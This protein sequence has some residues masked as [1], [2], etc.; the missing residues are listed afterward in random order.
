MEAIRIIVDKAL[1]LRV[2]IDFEATIKPI[3]MTLRKRSPNFN[4]LAAKYLKSQNFPD[5]QEQG[6]YTHQVHRNAS[7]RRPCSAPTGTWMQTN[8]ARAQPHPCR[9][10]K[11]PLASA[12]PAGSAVASIMA[13]IKPICRA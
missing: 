1:T 4:E 7:Q 12:E 10:S 6:L 11:C 9:N 8:N 5:W 13:T 3:V 2:Q